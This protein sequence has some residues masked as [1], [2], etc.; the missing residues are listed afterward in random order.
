MKKIKQKL[1][2]SI[3]NCMVSGFLKKT[4]KNLPHIPKAKESLILVHFL[5]CKTNIYNILLLFIE[6]EI[7][8]TDCVVEMQGQQT[9]LKNANSMDKIDR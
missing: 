3:R 7:T 4:N 6:L 1:A 5:Q 8:D 9:I 2:H